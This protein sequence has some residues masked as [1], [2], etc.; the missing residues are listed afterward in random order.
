MPGLEIA[1]AIPKSADPRLRLMHLFFK[2]VRFAGEQGDGKTVELSLDT[3]GSIS[4]IQGS[5]FSSPKGIGDILAGAPQCQECMVKQYFRYTY[6]R[7]ETTADHPVIQAAFQRFR[8]SQFNFKEV[9]ISV[10]TAH[11]SQK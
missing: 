1:S 7:P 10:I 9:M 6:G 11:A 4:G 3:S 5:E 8:N 2:L